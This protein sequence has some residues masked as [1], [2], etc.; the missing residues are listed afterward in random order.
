MMV[1]IRKLERRSDEIDLRIHGVN[2]DSLEDDH[3]GDLDA[4]SCVSIGSAFV[5][6]VLSATTYHPR[7]KRFPV[8]S[9]YRIEF[10]RFFQSL[11]QNKEG[12]A[13]RDS[14]VKIRKALEEEGHHQR[15]GVCGWELWESAGSQSDPSLNPPTGIQ[16]EDAYK[17]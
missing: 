17:T 2:S 3:L 7:C 16:A 4:E 11:V 12:D 15:V 5:S 8:A 9:R 6:D 13:F 14:D 10:L 1:N